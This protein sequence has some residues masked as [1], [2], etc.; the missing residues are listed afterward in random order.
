MKIGSLLVEICFLQK[1]LNLCVL[2]QKVIREIKSQSE[3]ITKNAGCC[4]NKEKKKKK[5]R[6]WQNEA[7]ESR[8]YGR[9]G[10]GTGCEML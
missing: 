10:H 9:K 6:R 5:D 3:E 4:T 7:A 2:E 8:N 1:A